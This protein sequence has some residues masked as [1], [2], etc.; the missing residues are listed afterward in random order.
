MKAIVA[1]YR[2]STDKQGKSG[3]GLEAQREC[4]QVLAEQAGVPVLAEFTEVESGKR[5]QR[6]V[7]ADAIA[8]AKRK[9]ATLVVAKVDRLSRNAAFLFAL[10]DSGI[11]V[12]FC[13]MPDANKLTIQLMA[14]VA[15]AE[16]EAIST[17]TKA[18]LTALKARGV[19]L[20]TPHTAEKNFAAHR[21]ALSREADSVA[22]SIEPMIRAG[23]KAGDSYATIA[24]TITESRI[25]TATG[26]GEWSAKQVQRYA[27]R[28]EAA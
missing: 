28:L 25:P 10:L 18:A 14:V 5:N 17:R 2:V 21:K 16:A 1:Y 12:T 22:R 13:D 27:K 24:K 3:L 8:E 20:G 9:K 11:D 4:V 23:R 6:P 15:E 7:L 26:R 19:K